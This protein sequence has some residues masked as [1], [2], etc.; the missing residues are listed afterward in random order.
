[1]G[2]VGNSMRCDSHVHIIGPIAQY[3]QVKTRT[4]L[5]PPASLDELTR[6]AAPCDVTR[7]VLVQPS[8]YGSDNTVLLESLDALG[9]RG[10]GVA[11]IDPAATSKAMLED[12]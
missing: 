6:A 5:A 4:Y 8:F 10:R 9:P 11:V 1:M 7:F 3:P 2:H 12:N